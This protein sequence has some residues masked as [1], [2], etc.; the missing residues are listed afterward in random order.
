MKKPV[1]AHLRRSQALLELAENKSH[2]AHVRW[3]SKDLGSWA[4]LNPRWWIRGEKIHFQFRGQGSGPGLWVASARAKPWGVRIFLSSSRNPIPEAFEVAWKDRA[5]DST[6]ADAHQLWMTVRYWLRCKFPVHQIMSSS[7]RP[8]LARSL[9]GTFLRVQF[10][11]RGKDCLLIAADVDIGEATH[12]ALSQ[13]LLWLAALAVKKQIKTAP[14]IHIL[15]PSGN[16]AMLVHRCQH[17]NDNRVKITVWEYKKRNADLPEIRR[18]TTPRVP[19]EEKD[20]RWPVL[21]PFRWSA[22]LE[23][24][25]HLAPD[26]IRRYPRFQ[27]YDSLRLWGLEFARVMGAERD[28]ICFGVGSQRTE[29]TEDNFDS[30]R[31]LIQEVL[32]YRRP[33]SPD[34]QHPYYR[35]QSERW[36][37]ALILED[38][39]RLF[40]ELAAESVY[41]QIPVYLGNDPGRIDILGADRQGTLAVMELKVAADP[42]LPAQALDY[43]GRVIQHNQNGDF[44]RRGYF[45]EVLLNR[46][47]PKIYLV[48]PVFSYHDSTEFLLRYLSSDLEVWKISINEDWRCGVKVMRRIQYRCSD[49]V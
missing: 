10:R 41:S 47:L 22:L 27:D 46:K 24:V 49:L 42:D 34:T 7:K 48:S 25:L 23:Q 39:P 40:P 8:D 20:F 43:W 31:A 17:L 37:E 2:E 35:L 32:Y 11:Y 44:E 15:V 9:S 29:L 12:L 18:A 1:A 36:L 33:D 6:A 28:R 3:R 5:A 19:E 13:A 16:S 38:I 21:G 4:D 30:L 26:L 14:M 45:S